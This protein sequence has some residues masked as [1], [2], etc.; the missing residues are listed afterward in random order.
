MAG[1]K[2]IRSIFWVFMSLLFIKG[3]ISFAQGNRTINQTIING[4]DAPVIT[5][6][7]KGFAVDFATEYFTWDANYVAERSTRLSNFVKGVDTEM[8]LKSLDVKGSSKVTS[9]EIYSTN[10]LDP[11]HI[12]VTVVV[13][14]DVQPLPDQL[15]AAQA[16][17]TT[18]P[19]VKK[20]TYMIVP[21][22]LAA[23][24]PVIQEYPRFVSNQQKGD[25]VDSSTNGTTVGDEDL[26]QKSNALADSFLRSWYEGN[27]SQLRYFYAETVKSPNTIPKSDYTYE[28]ID[29]V[30]VYKNPAQAGQADTYRIEANVIV[31]SDLGEPFTNTWK[32]QVTQKDGRLYVL[33]NGI[34]LSEA[35]EVPAVPESLSPASETPSESSPPITTSTD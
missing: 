7:I 18:P 16:K 32:L 11:D 29:K 35:S 23:E 19:V 10:L 30:A 14:R 2:I 9:A 1:K 28:A 17:A 33:S 31:E 22:T 12:D 20:K 27:A 6:S 34:Q 26:L 15:E 25:T 3:A 24:G 13:W 8:G 4:N 5:D 21:V